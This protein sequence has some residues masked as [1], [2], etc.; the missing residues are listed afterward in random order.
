MWDIV[1]ELKVA[2]ESRTMVVGRPG[3]RHF[4]TTGYPSGDA[5]RKDQHPFRMY[6]TAYGWSLN[7]FRFTKCTGSVNP[8]NLC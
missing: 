8:D 2:G 3:G 1:L 7:K 4:R 5:P 6:L